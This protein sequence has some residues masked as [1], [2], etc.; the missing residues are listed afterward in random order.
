M[1]VTWPYYDERNL[2]EDNTLV[3][4]P[5]RREKRARMKAQF[6]TAKNGRG[7]QSRRG[8]RK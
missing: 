7:K 2:F 1:P 5:N 8:K 4:V 6:R 3:V